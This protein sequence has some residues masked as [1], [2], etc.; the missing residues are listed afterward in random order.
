MVKH[1]ILWQI[2]D[3]F[4]DRADEL[5]ANARRELEALSGQIP[6]MR[7]ITLR[8]DPLASSNCDLM[9]E[10]TLD[11]EDALKAY[12]VDPKHVAVAKT[13]LIPYMKLRVCF[14]Y[15]V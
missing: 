14:D 9:L 4:A 1:I 5:R 15:E 13:Y 8:I 10:V 11:T 12:G 7:D 3:E 6:G 2:K